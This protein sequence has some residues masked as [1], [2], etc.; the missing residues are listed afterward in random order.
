MAY[1]LLILVG[2]LSQLHQSEFPDELAVH[3][4]EFRVLGA[5]ME[6]VTSLYAKYGADLK[7]ILTDF[8]L[9]SHLLFAVYRENGTEFM[10]A[11]LYYDIQGTITDVFVCVTKIQFWSPESNVYVYQLGSD[12]CEV[13]FSLIRTITHDKNCDFLQLGE[14]L[15]HSSTMRAIFRKHPEWRSHSAR[16]LSVDQSVDHTSTAHWTGELKASSVDC[17]RVWRDGRIK[18]EAVLLDCAWKKSFRIRQVLQS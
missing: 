18:A 16:R 14:R 10:P 17:E 2:R 5:M 12:E 3:L 8:S 4:P 11:Q 7:S 6:N 15:Q 13:L 1:Q 9:I